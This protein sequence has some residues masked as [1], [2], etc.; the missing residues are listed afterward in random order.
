MKRRETLLF[1]ALCVL[2]LSAYWPVLRFDFL[3]IDDNDYVTGNATVAGGLTRDGVAWAFTSREAANW[4]PVT[5][6]SHMLDVQIFGLKP[7]GHHLVNLLLHLVSA[8][9]LLSFLKAS[10]GLFWPS[11]LTAVLFALHPLQIESVAW[12]SERKTVLAALCWIL[13]MFAY[14][15][16]LRRPDLRRYLPVVGLFAVGLMAKPLVVTLPFALLLL[17]F[18]PFG[19]IGAAPRS[20][21]RCS[22]PPVSPA[23]LIRE[24][25]PLFLLSGLSSAITYIAQL[26]G[27]TVRHFDAVPLAMRVSNAVVSYG[28]Y[29]R[30]V[31]WPAGLS[32]FYPYPHEMS[33][34]WQLVGA[35]LLLIVV[36]GAVCSRR[37]IP[38]ALVGW[39]WFLGTLVPMIGLVQVGDQAMADRYVYVP[40]IGLLTGAAWGLR[41]LASRKAS[42]RGAVIVLTL[43]GVFSLAAAT[44]LQVVHWK[45]D[46]TLYRHGLAV[47]PGNW[48]A[49]YN[50]GVHYDVVGRLAEAE[51]LLRETIHLR[52]GYGK[53]H[54]NLGN[55]L[56]RTG[57]LDEA[58]RY[59]R[60]A[61]RTTPGD[62]VKLSNLGVAL[63][64]SGDMLEA[65]QLQRAALRLAPDNPEIHN[66]MGSLL[67]RTGRLDAALAE[68]TRAIALAPGRYSGYAHTA[69]THYLLGH[70]QESERYYRQALA[71][72]P[73]SPESRAEL[74]LV[75]Q[76]LRERDEQGSDA[77]S[78]H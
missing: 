24:K 26:E 62:A 11:A 56:I 51:T 73:G 75:R 15:R 35:S 66:N 57:R 68:F 63:A 17:D 77:K 28:N 41:D 78:V 72:N 45:D 16:Y 58:I 31:L 61:V 74:E 48:L 46:E 9:L 22:P 12:I 59:F 49:A 27:G 21:V 29:L 50:L 36:T 13:A 30:Q 43:A 4:H 5:W 7:G 8:V 39:L 64:R 25:A 67:L 47:D 71:I 14:L 53:A 23:R 34:G 33:P 65:E 70:F 40:I 19:R 52:P 10:T 54:N 3:T 32:F 69:Y 76:K 42:L 60:E 55:I 20:G 18:W 2:V 1:L 38:Y 37:T 44:R 6:L